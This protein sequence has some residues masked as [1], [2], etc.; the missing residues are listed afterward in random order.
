VSEITTRV[1]LLTAMIAFFVAPGSVSAAYTS[2]N[3]VT[4][5]TAAAGSPLLSQDFSTY[6]DNQSI[7]GI[8]FLSE[9]NVT[10]NMQKVYV[11]PGKFLFAFDD[12]EGARNT[13]SAYYQINL[14]NSYKAVGF[15]IMSWE[16]GTDASVSNAGDPGSINILFADNTTAQM[17]IY[18]TVNMQAVFFGVVSDKAITSIQWYEPHENVSFPRNEETALDNFIVGNNPANTP[19]PTPTPEPATMLLLGLGIVGLAGVRG[20]RK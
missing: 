12:G 10:A 2:Y 3:N 8:N 17:D 19:G 14:N 11:W 5:F 9:V 15:D 13:G 6:S 1:L 7:K 4:A 18:Q 20:S 16:I